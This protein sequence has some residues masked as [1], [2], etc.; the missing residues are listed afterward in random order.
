MSFD[1]QE[2][3][4]CKICGLP[5]EYCVCESIAKEDQRVRVA[6]EF[7]KWRK[8][9]T[10]ISGIDQKAVDLKDLAVKL[11]SKLACGGTVKDGVI[12]LQGDHRYRVVE[13]LKEMGFSED[14]I[15]LVG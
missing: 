8:P 10:V 6:L 13:L 7:R 5:T 3:T 4:I 9:Y 11:K 15:D 12:E 14:Q 1:D 2:S